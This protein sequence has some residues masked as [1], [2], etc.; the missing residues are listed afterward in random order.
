MLVLVINVMMGTQDQVL[1]AWRAQLERTQKVDPKHLQLSARSVLPVNGVVQVRHSVMIASARRSATK[2]RKFVC[3][4]QALVPTY[5][6]RKDAGAPKVSNLLSQQEHALN[7]RVELRVWLELQSAPI[8]LSTPTRIQLDLKVAPRAHWGALLRTLA[9][10]LIVLAP[11]SI[12]FMISQLRH[13]LLA[14]KVLRGWL[15]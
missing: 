8:V 15:K 1:C 5:R 14:L 4:V 12:K 11:S 3:R 10:T 2:E 9:V 7:V 6:R 13:A